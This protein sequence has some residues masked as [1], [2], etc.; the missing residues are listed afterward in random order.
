[1]CILNDSIKYGLEELQWI[2]CI[3]IV[4]KKKMQVWV[5]KRENAISKTEDTVR[6]WKIQNDIFAG[7]SYNL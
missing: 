1:M 7:S 6:T 5:E 3:E 4:K 2:Y